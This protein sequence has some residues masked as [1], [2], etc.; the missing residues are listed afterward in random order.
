[1]VSY[2]SS[3]AYLIWLL[4]ISSHNDGINIQPSH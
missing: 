2:F 1:M 3:G 4:N